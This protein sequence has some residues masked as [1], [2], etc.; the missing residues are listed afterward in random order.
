M[1][2]GLVTPADVHQHGLVA[3]DV[4]QS[5]GVALVELGNGRGFAVKDMSA[6]TDEAQ[7]SPVRELALYDVAS[8]IEDLRGLLPMCREHDQQE[9]L[10]VLEALM[11]YRRIDQLPAARSCRDHDIVA[12]FGR[13]L[14]EWHRA[15]EAVAGRL[16]PA[17]PWLLTIDTTDRLPVL[18]DPRFEPVVAAVL[19]DTVLGGVPEAC[20]SQWSD[21]WLVHGDVRFSNVLVGTSPLDVRLVDWEMSGRGDARWD[22]AGAIQEYL[23]MADGSPSSIVSAEGVEAAATWFA[24]YLAGLGQALSWDDARPFVAGRILVRAV[25][26]AGMDSPDRDAMVERHLEIARAVAR[27]DLGLAGHGH[28]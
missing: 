6:P 20:R 10:L 19:D 2:K 17:W 21:R 22:A 23:T 12:L 13:A 5:N 7:G 8:Q 4:S 28:R 18:D 26:C 9:H 25:Q 14:G 24:A 16:V 1:A 11:T 3:R 27:G 15:S